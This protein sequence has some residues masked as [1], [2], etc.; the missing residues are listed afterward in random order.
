MQIS[1]AAAVLLGVDDL[2]IVIGMFNATVVPQSTVA[3]AA[4]AVYPV[5]IPPYITLPAAL[6][7]LTVPAICTPFAVLTM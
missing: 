2:L 7:T 3:A 4:V 1:V 6:L 5:G